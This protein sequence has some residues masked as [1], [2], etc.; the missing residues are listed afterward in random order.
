[1][2]LRTTFLLALL[3]LAA[4]Y[5]PIYG[6]KGFSASATAQEVKLNHVAISAIGDANGQHLRNLLIDRFYGGGRPLKTDTRLEVRLHS[7]EDQLGLQKDATTTRSRLTITADYALFDT[8]TNKQIFA[9]T[10]HS[11]ASY[12][13]L[14]QQYATLAA[15]EDANKRTLQ[16]LADLITARLLLFFNHPTPFTPAAPSPDTPPKTPLKTDETVR[17]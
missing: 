13:I 14:D 3:S 12:S 11:T 7:Q 6:N 15:K 5:A 9:A 17:Q 4:C 1:M 2:F 10:S 16:E 8:A